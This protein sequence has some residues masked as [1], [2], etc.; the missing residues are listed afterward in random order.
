R[1][2]DRTA[3]VRLAQTRRRRSRRAPQDARLITALQEAMPRAVTVGEVTSQVHQKAERLEK[4]Y[5]N[6]TY[7]Q[8][9]TPPIAE[10]VIGRP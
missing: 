1:R 8:L 3:P 4:R 2:P 9:L 6:L 7:D 10:L 5:P